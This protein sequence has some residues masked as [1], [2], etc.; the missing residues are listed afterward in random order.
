MVWLWRGHRE[1]PELEATRLAQLR[2][3]RSN[4]DMREVAWS[5]QG[6]GMVADFDGGGL[7]GDGDDE[8]GGLTGSQG[9]G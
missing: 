9:S 1:I 2:E 5:E 4:G 7:P 3:A 6:H 8:E